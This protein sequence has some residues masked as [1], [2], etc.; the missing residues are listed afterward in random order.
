MALNVLIVQPALAAYRVPVFR[1]LASRPGIELRVAYSQVA[2]IP[3]ATPDGFLACRA[4]HRNLSRRDYALVW[5]SP[6]REYFRPDWCDCIVLNWNTRYLSLVP[7][8]L[9]ARSMRVPVILWGHGFSKQESGLRRWLR[10]QSCRLADAILT[11]NY[12]AA[13]SLVRGGIPR[14]RV[15]VALNSLDQ[16]PIQSARAQWIADQERLAAFKR[17]HGLDAGPVLL[18]CSRLDPANRVDMLIAATKALLPRHPGLRTVVIGG[19]PHQPELEEMARKLGVSG[20]VTF[21]GAMYGEAQVAPW[22]VSSSA[23]VYPA[24]IGLSILHAMG[25]GL[26]VITSDRTDTQNPEIE[27]MQH[28]HN[29][30][31][32]AHDSQEA[33]NSAIDRMLTD[34]ALRSRLAANA[35]DT[36]NR[37]FTIPRMVDGLE[38]AIR[39]A[40]R[41]KMAARSAP[42]IA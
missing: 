36:A 17:E 7:T 13:D 3:N 19:G 15:F 1:D 5:Q 35:H 4:D 24:N 22:F 14:T 38:S 23:F 30:L 32:Y 37:Q 25:Y 12:T 27:A 40:A 16:V 9:E 8:M 10:A 31:T 39:F 42:A 28:E 21:T 26:P 34:T 20:R 11:Y 18:F 33:L 6:P 41:M 2:G 29:G